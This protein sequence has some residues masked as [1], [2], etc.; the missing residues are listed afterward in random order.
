M[1]AEDDDKHETSSMYTD[2]HQHEQKQPVYMSYN[3]PNLNGVSKP[4]LVRTS[5]TLKPFSHT[6]PVD[7]IS[8]IKDDKESI[9]ID[10]TQEVIDKPVILMNSGLISNLERIVEIETFVK[11]MSEES[12][13]MSSSI[14]TTIDNENVL[15][16]TTT[17]TMSEMIHLYLNDSEKIILSKEAT[18]HSEENSTFTTVNRKIFVTRGSF[19]KIL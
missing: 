9:T 11:D 7:K 16:L 14:E 4:H 1:A 3:T 15:K 5:G 17:E 13:I 12:G 10:E 2:H 19:I 18:N 6:I 8:P